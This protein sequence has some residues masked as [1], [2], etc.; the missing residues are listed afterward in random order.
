MVAYGEPAPQG[1]KNARAIY[2]GR[3][4][5]RQFTGKVAV[6]ESSKKVKPWR[7]AVAEVARAEVTARVL[8]PL[9]GPLVVDMVFTMPKGT[10]LPKWKAWHDTSPDLSKLARS[11]EDALNGLVW[12][13]DARVCAYRRLE[14]VYTGSD[15]PDALYRPGVLVRVWKVPEFL[16]EDRKDRARRRDL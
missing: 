5:Q 3:G 7:A 6:H 10:T 9:D 15:D 16:I 1:S 4:E 8:E 11:T 12:V 14:A 2:K 13:D